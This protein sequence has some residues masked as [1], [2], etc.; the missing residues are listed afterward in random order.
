MGDTPFDDPRFKDIVVAILLSEIPGGRVVITQAKID[1]IY[2]RVI[3]EDGF[4]DDHLELYLT[5]QKH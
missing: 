4:A 2:G 5:D 1:I 3:S